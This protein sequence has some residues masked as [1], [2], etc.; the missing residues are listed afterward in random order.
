ML[1]NGTVVLQYKYDI[2]KITAGPVIISAP[3]FESLDFSSQEIRDRKY[4]DNL[5]IHFYNGGI[6]KTFRILPVA[7]AYYFG[8]SR[9]NIHGNP[10]DLVPAAPLA[11]MPNTQKTL[12]M[13]SFAG[14]FAFRTCRF[15]HLNTSWW[16]VFRCVTR[17]RYQHDAPECAI[18]S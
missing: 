12:Q 4:P 16:C 3:T 5:V 7:E 10:L 9:H 17:Y 2:L 1:G 8:F 15:V 11:A 6:G 14:F 13:S 18:N